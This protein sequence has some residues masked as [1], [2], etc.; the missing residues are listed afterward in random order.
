MS[1]A[2]SVRAGSTD[3][4]RP[5]I[6]LR[7]KGGGPGPGSGLQHSPGPITKP[8][9][10]LVP[11]ANVRVLDQLRGPDAA[12]IEVLAAMMAADGQLQP[13]GLVSA[14]S[15]HALLWGLQRL[16]AAAL[17]G[18]NEIDAFIYPQSSGDDLSHR[19]MAILEN[20]G[21][22]ELN[23]LD[24]AAYL[25]ALKALHLE[26]NPKSGRGGD[27]KSNARKSKRNVCGLKFS[28][29]AAAACGLSER[30]VELAVQIHGG[31]ARPIRDRLAGTWLADNQAGLKLL[32]DQSG[33]LQSRVLDFLFSEPVKA[34]SVADAIT[35]ATG[36]R[37]ANPSEKRFRA[38]SDG[39]ARVSQRERNAIFDLYEDEIVAHA[40][41]RGWL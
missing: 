6:A 7:P 20:V 11:M 16:A 30:A 12:W 24:R 37:L 5:E 15:D 4:S 23:A 34:N 29:E 41:S 9:R 39:L 35:L 21:R 22:R 27:R 8:A 25:A 1:A 10:A 38:L 19:R 28:E 33:N 36:G 40:K 26:M 31:L 2:L 32:S 13:I 18:W 3:A 17:L 14:G